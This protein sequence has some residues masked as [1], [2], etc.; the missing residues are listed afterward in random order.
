M[1]LI[2][3]RN[4]LDSNGNRDGND[5]KDTDC[6]DAHGN[7]DARLPQLVLCVSFGR[8]KEFLLNHAFLFSSNDGEFDGGS[9][10]HWAAVVNPI[11]LHD[12]PNLNPMGALR[13]RRREQGRG[14]RWL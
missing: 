9:M 7:E 5:R 13:R 10:R 11:P 12:S 8:I 6:D 3:S 14:G 4:L 1:K 2:S